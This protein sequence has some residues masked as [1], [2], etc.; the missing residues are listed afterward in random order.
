MASSHDDCK[1]SEQDTVSNEWNSMAGEWDDLARGYSNSFQ[2]VIFQET[3]IQDLAKDATS[4]APLTILDF[5]C[6][7]GLLTESLRK[8]LSKSD[9]ES[10]KFICLDAASEMIK[11]VKEKIRAGEWSNVIAYAIVL[12]AL[13]ETFEKDI[14]QPLYGTVDI[15][16]ASSVLVFIPECDIQATMNILGKLLKPQ[17]GILIHSDWPKDN[18]LNQSNGFTVERAN[19]VHGYASLTTKTA[20]VIEMSMGG[21]GPDSSKGKVFLGIAIKE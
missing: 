20:K 7:T 2:Q 12:A 11:V 15:I 9:D 6:G 18:N 21:T 19:L 5:G 16:V 1:K 14:L 13:D 17:K 8:K 3:N 10:T 4:D